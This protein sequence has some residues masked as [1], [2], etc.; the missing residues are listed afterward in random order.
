MSLPIS[1]V[2]LLLRCRPAAIGRLVMTIVVLAV[3]CPSFGAS[4]HVSEE[5]L[6]RF[7]PTSAHSYPPA[8]PPLVAT[9]VW[10]RSS[11]NGAPP[12]PEFSG[13]LPNPSHPVNGFHPAS[14]FD[15]YTS[16]RFSCPVNKVVLPDYFTVPAPAQTYPISVIL[17]FLGRFAF[18][19]ESSYPVAFCHVDRIIHQLPNSSYL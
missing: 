12:R 11:V 16:A 1:I 15:P 19:D 5:V 2:S 9:T 4:A 8:A 3:Q 7:L 10:V 18:H 6:K 13:N 17:P 14:V